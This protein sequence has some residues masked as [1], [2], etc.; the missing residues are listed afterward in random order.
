M[1]VSYVAV[2]VVVLVVLVV[3]GGVVVFVT[4]ET[5]QVVPVVV[6]PVG[7]VSTQ[8]LFSRSLGAMHPVQLVAE[9]LQLEQG[10]VQATHMFIGEA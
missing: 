2:V 7:Q 10:A 5:T 6:Y 8:L 1:R 9:L 4:G 3:T